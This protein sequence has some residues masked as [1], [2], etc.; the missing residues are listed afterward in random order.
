MKKIVLY[1]SVCIVLASCA[2]VVDHQTVL[3]T[4]KTPGAE[5]A[6][7]V[8]EN[9]D[10]KYVAYSD[11]TIEI[12]KSPHDLTVRCMA[13]GNRDNTILVRREIN[14]WVAANILNGFVPGVTYDYFSRG[15]FDYPDVVEVSFVG[16]PVKPYPLPDYMSDDLKGDVLHKGKIPYNGPS[17]IV[18]EE[19]RYYQP[20]ELNKKMNNYENFSGFGSSEPAMSSA[21][22]SSYKTDLPAVSYDPTEEDK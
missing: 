19:D 22:A 12:M 17:T 9:E 2:S 15:G 4:M 14:G 13:P 6:K 11:Q 21:P 16:I 18:T 8:I 10:M 3:M 5:N 20:Q 1:S 7:C